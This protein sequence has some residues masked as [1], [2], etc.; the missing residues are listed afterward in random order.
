MAMEQHTTRTGLPVLNMVW[1]KRYLI[2]KSDTDIFTL[3][4]EGGLKGGTNLNRTWMDGAMGRCDG[5]VNFRVAQGRRV[6]LRKKELFHQ[7]SFQ[8]MNLD[9]AS[10][11]WSRCFEGG[12]ENI[13][14]D[15]HNFFSCVDPQCQ[16][17]CLYKSL[18]VLCETKYACMP[19]EIGLCRR[20]GVECA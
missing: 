7:S 17:F 6:V 16:E 2:K 8:K 19:R 14:L 15:S 11:E 10:L 5:G 12:C 1:L 3:Y 9:T 13:R 20:W 4:H 18:L